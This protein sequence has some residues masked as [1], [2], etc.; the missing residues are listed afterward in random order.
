[1]WEVT[2]NTKNGDLDKQTLYESVKLLWDTPAPHILLPQ[3]KL[4]TLFGVA[5]QYLL[6]CSTKKS[7]TYIVRI[8]DG[9][10]ANK[11]ARKA[12]N[13]NTRKLLQSL[14]TPRKLN[15]GKSTFLLDFFPVSSWGLTNE[16][17]PHKVRA[18]LIVKNTT[19]RPMRELDMGEEE[20]P[21]HDVPADYYLTSL[22][23]F[24]PKTIT[25]AHD[26]AMDGLTPVTFPFIKE[27]DESISGLTLSRE[28]DLNALNEEDGD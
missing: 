27:E 24:V 3:K 10:L 8:E 18:C 21:H 2:L 4:F 22:L 16:I 12:K 17:P 6:F 1:M 13:A 26:L 9:Q 20:S 11:L 5:F 15:Y 25:I 14:L 28:I 19:Q 7:G 23:K